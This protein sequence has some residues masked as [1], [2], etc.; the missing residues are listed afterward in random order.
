MEA[1][2]QALRSR[3]YFLVGCGAL[4]ALL[5][6][7]AGAVLLSRA[8]EKDASVPPPASQAGLVVETKTDVGRALDP[9]A[10]LRC[11]VGGRFVGEATLAECAKKNGVATGA[12]DVGVDPGGNLA[13]AQ[14]AGV[15]L[16]P[17]PPKEI[18]TAEPVTVDASDGADR[19]SSRSA[20]DTCWRYAAGDWRKTPAEASLDACVQVLFN[21][22]CVHSGDAAYGRWGSMTLRLVAGRVESS[23]DNRTFSPLTEQSPNCVVAPVP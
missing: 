3:P 12:L 7:L 11:F 17:L 21:G 2:W 22:R 13:A 23:T 1:I 16:T 19:R 10:H 15:D 6:G 5:A 4:V 9:M 18:V 14:G 8:H 20:P